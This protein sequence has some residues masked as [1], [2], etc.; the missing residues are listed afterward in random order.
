MLIR[1]L[2]TIDTI[3]TV[4]TE[5]GKIKNNSNGAGIITNKSPIKVVN[6]E[7]CVNQG[8]LFNYSSVKADNEDEEKFRRNSVIDVYNLKNGAYEHSFYIPPYKGSKLKR[9]AVY[10]QTL[11]VIYKK[12]IVVYKISSF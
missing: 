10:G 12:D 3:S 6:Y 1:K 7:S 9:F 8:K 2:K 4:Q 11:V 5:F